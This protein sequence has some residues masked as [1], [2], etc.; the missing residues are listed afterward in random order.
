VHYGVLPGRRTP[1]GAL[2]TLWFVH[3]PH[4]WH[5]TTSQEWLVEVD[6]ESGE[7][8]TRKQLQSRFTHDAV[9]AG[10]RVHVCN[11]DGGEVVTLAYPG[12]EQLSASKLFTSKDHANTLA[13][14]TADQLWVVLH[15]LGKSDIVQLV[16]SSSSSSSSSSSVQ[17]TALV[18]HAR[19]RG[20]GDKAHGLIA[21]EGGFLTLDSDNGRLLWIQPGGDGSSSHGSSDGDSSG[22]RSRSR[23]S[24]QGSIQQAGQ[25][26]SVAS[27]P[28]T[29]V[30]L[31]EVPPDP[32]PQFLKGLAVVDGV[33]YFGSSPQSP[34][35]KRDNP[36]LS[37][38]LH[39]YDLGQRKLLWSRPV[40]TQGLLNVIAAPHLGDASTYAPMST[41]DSSEE[42]PT[43]AIA[44]T[45]RA[46]SRLLSSRA[47]GGTAGTTGSGQQAEERRQLVDGV[48]SDSHQRGSIQSDSSSEQAGDQG[49]QAGTGTGTGA[50]A[51]GATNLHVSKHDVFHAIPDDPDGS[52]HPVKTID[53]KAVQEVMQKLG[54]MGFSPKV[55]GKWPSGYPYLDLATKD[56]PEPWTAGVQLPIAQLDITALQRKIATMPLEYWDNGYQQQHNAFVHGRDSNMDKFKPGVGA[57]F[58]VFSD[59]GASHSYRFPFYDYFKQEMEALVRQVVGERGMRRMVRLQFARMPPGTLIHMH[60]DMGGYALKAHRIH[61]PI[62]AEPGVKFDVCAGLERRLGSGHRRMITDHDVGEDGDCVMLPMAEGM[63]FELN[64]RL[65]HRVANPTNWT[66]IQLV[67]DVA[68][69]EKPCTTLKPGAN[70]EYVK[71]LVQCPHEV[72]VGNCEF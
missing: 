10:S 53:D 66:R 5:P 17:K 67:L 54:D 32:Q 28:Y 13:P 48:N 50:S 7:V 6:A 41:A 61:L 21:W 70:C 14:F 46:V 63:V 18:E 47:V 42:V 1:A 57:L 24:S 4:N 55:G 40:A 51:G 31:H 45:L 56:G 39:A 38:T 27:I 68:E 58:L 72:V 26:D 43:A 11:T 23:S 30:V 44:E 15:N 65:L 37:C 59:S 60:R 3:R 69:E 62:F 34:R 20:V 22:S 71:G 36:D 49:Q 35:N 64:N 29:R 25:A 8:T 19:L 33:A 16:P 2:R 52:E 9:R 12:M